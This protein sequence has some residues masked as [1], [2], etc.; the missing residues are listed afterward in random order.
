M[1][2][3]YF[4]VMLLWHYGIMAVRSR[5]IMKHKFIKGGPHQAAMGRAGLEGG[6]EVGCGGPSG[7]ERNHA[8]PNTMIN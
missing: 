3:W 7:T 8:E 4:G 1:A 2:L 6:P 5:S